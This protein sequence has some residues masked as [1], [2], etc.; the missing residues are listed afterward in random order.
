M[1]LLDADVR[2]DLLSGQNDG[3]Q[4]EWFKL[5]PEREPPNSVSP[6]DLFTSL[7]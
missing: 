2:M 4:S 5:H 1:M 3:R 6:P 7:P